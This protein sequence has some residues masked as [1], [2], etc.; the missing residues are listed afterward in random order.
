[1]IAR[2][3]SYGLTDTAIGP[4]LVAVE[5][6]RVLGWISITRVRGGGAA[7]AALAEVLR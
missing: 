3:A 7:P 1:M 4:L 2:H 6:E 5:E